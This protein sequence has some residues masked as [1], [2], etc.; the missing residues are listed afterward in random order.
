VSPLD[1]ATAVLLA[2]A[3]IGLAGASA[4]AIVRRGRTTGL[5]PRMAL[6]RAGSYAVLAVALVIAARLGV[7]G[8]AV[9]F[10]ILGALGV[11]EWGRMF[12]LPLH[13][14]VA[15]VI[16]NCVIIGAIAVGG[17]GAADWLVGALVLVG[18]VWPV[19]RA[20]TGRAI[21]DLGM[22]AVG[23]IL[24]S[25]M[26]AH[27]VALGVEHGEAGI[28]LV[29]ALGVACAF[30]DVGAFVIGRTFGRTPLAP[31][32]SPNKTREG[33]A[34]NVLGAALGLAAFVPALVPVFGWPFVL[35]LVPLVAAGSL[36]GDLLES[37]AKREA[38]VK[39]AGAWL[40]GFGGIL[41]RIDSLLVTMAL[42]FWIARL[43]GAG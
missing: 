12:E 5:T 26:L 24:V 34:G 43:W 22:A 42:G 20:D 1:A 25:V 6:Q 16:A 31:R 28:A 7:P 23:V 21:R 18:A 2:G 37:A 13:H 30:S 33:V 11:I 35:A 41:D 27:G 10:G 38:G 9:L 19:A 14:R 17:V 15:T 3:V 40:P 29:L 4:Y 32:L 39:D 8:L 36:W